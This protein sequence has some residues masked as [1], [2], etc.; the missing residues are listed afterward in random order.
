MELFGDLSNHIME[1]LALKTQL[2][3]CIEHQQQ[4][5]RSHD[6][7]K[8]SHDSLQGSHGT[9][10]KNRSEDEATHSRNVSRSKT[11][12][13]NSSLTVNSSPNY[14][15]S[16]NSVAPSETD[17][18]PTN[19]RPVITSREDDDRSKC[20][21]LATEA[22]PISQE[23]PPTNQPWPVTSI[24]SQVSHC[25]QTTA[26]P[27]SGCH[28]NHLTTGRVQSSLPTTVQSVDIIPFSTP[29]VSTNSLSHGQGRAIAT[30][31]SSDHFRNLSLSKEGPSCTST[32]VSQQLRSSQAVASGA[33]MR[34]ES[35]N[36]LTLMHNLHH[37]YH[38]QQQLPSW[39]RHGHSEEHLRDGYLS[40]LAS[41]SVYHHPP[42]TMTQHT[43]SIV[44]PWVE[45]H[46]Q[47]SRLL[48]HMTKTTPRTTPHYSLNHH[49]HSREQQ[50]NRCSAHSHAER[51][52]PYPTSVGRVNHHNTATFSFGSW[53]HGNHMTVA[54]S[55]NGHGAP[56]G[57]S[58]AS[59]AYDPL[60]HQPHFTPTL[61]GGLNNYDYSSNY[62]SPQGHLPPFGHS[63]QNS[64]R[65]NNMMSHDS[66]TTPPYPIQPHP[67]S[68]SN[69]SATVWRPYSDRSRSSGFCLADILSLPSETET[70]P[71]QLE[72]TPPTGHRGMHSFLVNRLL[73]DI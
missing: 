20:G 64:T 16:V 57:R 10:N 5:Q 39:Q 56:L 46:Q 60:Q 38:H 62:S 73:E 69:S 2:Q 65:S 41:S 22:P 1:F 17:A 71:L 26:T 59:A 3:Q 25:Q 21:A 35:G 19:Y 37:L 34:S 14:I 42:T 45:S 27:T 28:N 61:G 12:T 67:H 24:L 58:Y 32:T 66:T 6:Q 7:R 40:H 55:G 47:R 44:Q 11:Q 50:F 13:S 51:F 72:S 8:E 49:R 18:P 29:A 31:D 70:P 63:Q 52:E 48:H 30:Q 23:T 43:P 68:G 36:G 15:E 53:S 54:G 4:Q 9:T 33:H